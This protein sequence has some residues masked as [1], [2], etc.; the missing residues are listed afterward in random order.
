MS[1]LR[2]LLGLARPEPIDPALWRRITADLPFLGHL[3]EAELEMLES[4]CAAFLGAKQFSGA[5]GFVV[6][7][8]VRVA[9]A[10]QACLPALHLGLSGYRDFVEIVVYPDRFVAPRKQ[11]DDAGVVHEY[12]DELAGEAMQGGPVVLSWPD[13]DPAGGHVGYNVVIHEFVHKLDMLGGPPDG[14]PP[15]L[16][17]MRE[18]W[19]RTMS[20]AYEDFCIR[21]ERL[22]AAIPRHV[23]PESPAADA[24]YERLPLDPYAAS[25]PG[26]FFAVT[27]EAFF[28]APRA[29]VRAYPAVYALFRDYFRQDPLTGA[30]RSRSR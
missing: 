2:K 24:W 7:D 13:A 17:G 16:A 27:A 6:D 28:T 11:V 3:D 29:L 12:D 22:E 15:M 25:D 9:I 20:D 8:E 19:A 18:R 26:E 14:A 10:V 21:V 30:A 4:Q 5:A 1:L 23:D